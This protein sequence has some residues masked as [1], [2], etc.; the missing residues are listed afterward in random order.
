MIHLLLVFSFFYFSY[1]LYL[2]HIDMMNN[3]S[4]KNNPINNNKRC[5]L[6]KLVCP[7]CGHDM[8]AKKLNDGYIACAYCGMVVM[9]P[10]YSLELIDA[11]GFIKRYKF[12]Y[13]Q[14]NKNK[15]NSFIINYHLI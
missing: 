5:D 11:P 6:N 2:S 10:K 1:F 9:K 14:K 4:T 8:K 12:L 13:Q 3:N 7:D 15:K